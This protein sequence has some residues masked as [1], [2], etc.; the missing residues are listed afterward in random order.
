MKIRTLI[1]LGGFI[2]GI[3]GHAIAA[4]G[5]GIRLEHPYVQLG[6]GGAIQADDN[7]MVLKLAGGV[8]LTR[9]L[10]VEAGYTSLSNIFFAEVDILYLSLVAK[11]AIGEKATLAGKLGVARWDSDSTYDPLATQAGQWHGVN[12]MV[13][14]DWSYAIFK[15]V[16]IILSL[17]YY[18]S[19]NVGKSSGDETIFPGT[20]G[21]RYTF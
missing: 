10:G 21:I 5:Q 4:E 9:Q 13:G 3:P 2:L 19:M 12:G 20:I 17:E 14:V 1:L 15:H 18:G 7:Y 8:D 11:Y 6:V 16:G